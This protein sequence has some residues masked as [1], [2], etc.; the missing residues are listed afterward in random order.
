MREVSQSVSQSFLNLFFPSNCYFCQRVLAC[1]SCICE[2]CVKELEVIR[3]A[4]CLRC[5][6]PVAHD[7]ETGSP[8][9]IHCADLCFS[10]RRNESIGVFSGKLRELVH[11]FKF[12]K[13]RTLFKLFSR[14]ACE[15]KRSYVEMHHILV[16]VPLTRVR[17]SERG[18]NQSA[19]IA[20]ALSRITNIEYPGEI[21]KR[22][23]N[24]LPQSRVHSREMRYNN[25]KDSFVLRK[26]FF[27][28][29]RGKDILLVDDVLTTGA[30]ASACATVL[31][32]GGAGNVDVL[33]VGRTKV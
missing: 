14:L 19:L 11:L 10:F 5:G 2:S 18:F 7:E 22:V 16:P 1:G 29:I 8:G 24:S 12:Q 3:G 13:R 4:F 20:R 32:D 26:K 17:Y 31:Y 9:C 21:L 33:T 6:A 27:E 30:T 23:G 15:Y 28:L 25:M